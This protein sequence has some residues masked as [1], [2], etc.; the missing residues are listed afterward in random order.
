M[1]MDGT[2]TQSRIISGESS[3]WRA[4]RL[5]HACLLEA[6]AA[7]CLSVGTWEALSTKDPDDALRMRLRSTTVLA[8]ADQVSPGQCSKEFRDA[9]LG[10][11]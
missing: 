4:S 7:H 1:I 8:I 2:V 5:A 9:G 11:A 6:A 10:L 3:I